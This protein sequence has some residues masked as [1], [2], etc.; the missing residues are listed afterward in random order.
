[1]KIKFK[2]TKK[3]TR[4]FKL[5]YAW[6]P[7][8]ISE[9]QF[10]WLEDVYRREETFYKRDRTRNTTKYVS[11]EFYF[12]QA[13]RNAETLKNCKDDEDMCAQ[14]GQISAQKTR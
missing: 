6:R 4:E 13:M 8:R 2:P 11:K 5:W 7:V 12:T 14:N 3:L 9:N 1:M 10:A